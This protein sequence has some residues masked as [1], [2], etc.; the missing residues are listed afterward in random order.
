VQPRICMLSAFT[1]TAALSFGSAVTAAD[2]PKEGTFTATYA[3]AGT[4]KATS[5]G[6]DRVL[7]AFDENGLTVGNGLL[8]H[9]TWHSFGLFDVM[10]GMAEFQGY[11][12]GT[13]PAG[14][15]IVTT[16]ATDGRYPADTKT[17]SGKVTFTNGTGKYAGITGGYSFVNHGT[18]FRTAAEGTYVQYAAFQGS[19]KLP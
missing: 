13:D 17:V 9:M 6:K 2:V 7:A 14:D 19:Y 4:Y 10:N 3:S 11:G 16:F 15:Q 8:D 5:I 12:V 18:D 1:L